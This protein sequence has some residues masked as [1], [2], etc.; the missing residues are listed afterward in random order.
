MGM[1]SSVFS[2]LTDHYN[3]FVPCAPATDRNV[4]TSLDPDMC[5]AIIQEAQKYIGQV[6]QPLPLSLYMDFYKTG[7]RVHFETVY[8]NRRVILNILVLAECIE[9]KQRFMYCICDYLFA[10]CEE[11]GWQ[12]PAHNTYVRDTPQQPVPDVTRPV[13]D[14]F[15]CES[16]AQIAMVYYLLHDELFAVD[17]ALIK[18]IEY[19]LL[20]RIIHP[21]LTD[22][23][24]WMGYE[25]QATNN[26]TVWCTQNVLITS[27]LLRECIGTKKIHRIVRRACFS[28][29]RFLSE[30]GDDGCCD[31]GPQY[32]RHAGLCLGT[33]LQLLQQVTG[34]MYTAVLEHPKIRN[35]AEYIVHVHAQ[36]KYYLNFADSAAVA[37]AA[38]IR[39]YVLGK[40][41]GSDVLMQFAAFD[42]VHEYKP[43]WALR[44]SDSN[45]GINLFYLV[46]ELCTAQEV[47][48]YVATHPVPLAISKASDWAYKSAGVYISR[49]AHY[50]LGMKAGDNDDSHN[51]NDVGSFILYKDGNPFIIDVGVETYTKKTFS[52]DRYTIWTMQSLYHNVTNIDG[53][54]QAAGAQYKAQRV[55]YD[56]Q[57][58]VTT[59]SME[60]SH[61]YPA[62]SMLESYR[63]TISFYKEK[64]IIVTDVIRQ[65]A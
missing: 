10:L 5:Q 64:R 39:E 62:D 19:E 52:P 28:I 24:W 61:A 32:Y 15:A 50:C 58:D 46:Q 65:K 41:I 4:W 29:D 63:R 38:G 14:L 44:P 6:P 35:I 26:W 20:Q 49:D 17:P 59:L 60:L 42:W 21:Y 27:F 47:M 30:Y 18:R 11:S 1:V 12:L 23:F 33:A 54:M 3:Q 37:G 43:H 48:Q 9:Y 55:R 31:E 40:M 22:H 25:H 34:G 53:T 45:E 8:F 57:K 7:N 13:L 2:K 16:G 56:V 51:H 36:G